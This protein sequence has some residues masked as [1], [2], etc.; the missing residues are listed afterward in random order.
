MVVR[1][2]VDEPRSRCCCCCIFLSVI[3]LLGVCRNLL[4]GTL[5]RNPGSGGRNSSHLFS[6]SPFL[7]FWTWPKKYAKSSKL[8]SGNI[9]HHDIP[10]SI[11]C[12]RRPRTCHKGHCV[13]QASK[14]WV[15]SGPFKSS[16]RTLALPLCLQ[17]GH[18]QGQNP[19]Q[20]P[21][22]PKES[23][24]ASHRHGKNITVL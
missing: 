5:M 7:K 20:R 21:P 19:K 4:R 24:N 1:C 18:R 11:R 9:R 6:C 2:C 3:G 17:H 8:W 15:T 10:R 12:W 22:P 14:G 16:C 23:C 13:A